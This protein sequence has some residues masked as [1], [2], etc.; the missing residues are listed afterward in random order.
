MI[1]QFYSC[2]IIFERCYNTS[3]LSSFTQQISLRWILSKFKQ[4]FLLNYCNSNCHKQ[5][6]ILKTLSS[7]S[8]RLYVNLMIRN[9]CEE[10]I[11]KYHIT[12][13]KHLFV[14]VFLRIQRLLS[15]K[16]QLYDSL[17]SVAHHFLVLN[18]NFSAIIHYLQLKRLQ[19]RQKLEGVTGMKDGEQK[20][21]IIE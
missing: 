9:V 7:K 4:S 8:Q 20:R 3:E 21:K 18:N 1:L 14:L 17:P 15:I 5:L 6:T 16:S 11:L 2:Y 13:R 12:T 10:Q 19:N